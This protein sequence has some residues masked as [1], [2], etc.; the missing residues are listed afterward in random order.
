MTGNRTRL[1]ALLL[2]ASV[3]LNLFLGGLLLGRWHGPWHGWRMAG[4]H[5]R[6][7]PPGAPGRGRMP[8][9]EWL[10]QSLG[11]DAAPAVKAA[12]ARHQATM[13]ATRAAFHQARRAVGE[14]LAREPFDAA[15]YGQA[16]Q[17]LDG[18]SAAMRGSVHAM[19]ADLAPSLTAE[20]RQRIVERGSRPP[21]RRPSSD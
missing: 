15:A 1:L 12:L 6:P 21:A 13:E 3:A 8:V 19:M 14:A 16:L 5:H 7:G 11:E 9:H 18:A 2:F 4:E 20:Q 17:D 10:E